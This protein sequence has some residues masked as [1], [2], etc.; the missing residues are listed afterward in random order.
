[1]KTITLT[2]QHDQCQ[3]HIGTALL[4]NQILI[5][6]CTALGNHVIIITDDNVKNLYAEPLARHITDKPCNIISIAPG[7]QSKSREIKQHIEDQMLEL[8]CGR[9]TVIFAI[10][11]GIV[12][13]LA[14]FIAATYCRG[15][16]SIYFPTTLLAMVDASIGGKTAV[17]IS[18]GKNLIGCFY[19]PKMVIC[20]TNTLQ[21]L[22]PDELSNGFAE[23]I[24]HALIADPNLLTLLE[25]QLDQINQ[26]QLGHQQLINHITQSCQIKCDIVTQ[27]EHEHGLRQLLNFGHTIAH[28]IERLKNY[29]ISHGQAVSAG[30]WVESYLSNLMGYLS[31]ADFNQIN[32]ILN[33]LQ[34]SKSID[35]TADQIPELK[36]HMLLDKKSVNKQARFVL[37]DKVGQAHIENNQ[38]C[39]TA[40][41][42]LLDQALSL[43]LP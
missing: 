4:S 14:G 2:H 8:G 28:G 43:W 26:N 34:F 36:Q 7:E 42:D 20:D 25:A 3:I 23:S 1:M 29:Q 12:T 39:F 40:P 24:K 16:P 17:N 22:P 13:D 11:G 38:Y 27:D 31:D 30:L 10:G 19:Q 6:Q 41:E 33:K 21:T 32:T 35:I 15:I 5:Q 37:L 9:D 18:F